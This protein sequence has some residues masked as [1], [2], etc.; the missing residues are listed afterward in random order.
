MGEDEQP[1]SEEA[2]AGNTL[3]L[4]S[5]LLPD[6][7]AELLSSAMATSAHWH[8]FSPAEVLQLVASMSIVRFVSQT[9]L[10]PAPLA[11]TEP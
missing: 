1:R 6:E 9:G 11:P 8:G 2:R 3:A 7:A 5:D 10:E 4:A